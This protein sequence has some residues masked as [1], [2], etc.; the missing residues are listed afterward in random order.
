MG[1]FFIFLYVSKEKLGFFFAGVVKTLFTK[2][3]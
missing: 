3:L 2:L 1:C